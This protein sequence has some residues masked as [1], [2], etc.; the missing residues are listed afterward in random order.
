MEFVLL[1]QAVFGVVGW[2]CRYPPGRVRL[3]SVGD[4]SFFIIVFPLLAHAHT[5]THPVLLDST[6]G[7]LVVHRL[8]LP[9]LSPRHASDL[10]SLRHQANR[11][12]SVPAVHRAYYVA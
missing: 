7:Q 9:H 11:V 12:S 3:D 2:A 1:D 5:T 4:S 8:G 10:T 6:D